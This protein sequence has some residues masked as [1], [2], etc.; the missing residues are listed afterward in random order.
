MRYLFLITVFVT[1]SMWANESEVCLVVKGIVR[2][3]QKAMDSTA[4]SVYKN[5][6][7]NSMVYSDQKGKFFVELERNAVYRM[8]I[9]KEGFYSQ[10]VLFNTNHERLEA[11]CWS[12]KFVAELLPKI[13]TW[14]QKFFE[15]PM[16]SLSYDFEND[17]F[18]NQLNVEERKKLQKFLKKYELERLHSYQQIIAEADEAFNKALYKK[19]EALYREAVLLDSYSNYADIQ[20]DMIQRIRL[21][22]RKIEQ[23]F[24]N[25]IAMA[26]ICY[27]KH[28]F[29][30]AKRLYNK[31]LRLK[32]A[33]YPKSQIHSIKKIVSAKDI[34]A[35]H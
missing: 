23:K 1:S 7:F 18:S 19:A 5:D 2:Y 17:R 28:D 26:D 22:N 30:K 20:L 15:S 34:V 9:E 21:Q 4:I 11:G 3:E 31:A 10:Q 14:N 25:Y 6:T 29:D 35:R 32:D 12:Y 24:N 27:D 8:H 16:G 13:R 33:T